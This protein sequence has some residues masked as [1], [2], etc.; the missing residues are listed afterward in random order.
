MV[1]VRWMLLEVRAT[2]EES[3]SGEG[4]LDSVDQNGRRRARPDAFAP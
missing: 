3:F 4:A 2:A 1:D